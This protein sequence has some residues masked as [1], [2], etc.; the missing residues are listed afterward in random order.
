MRR[1]AITAFLLGFPLALAPCPAAMSQATSVLILGLGDETRTAAPESL[2]AASQELQRAVAL[3]APDVLPRLTPAALGVGGWGPQSLAE[4]GREQGASFVVRGGVLTVS[5][6]AAGAR[7]Y[8]TVQVYADVV[9]VSTGTVQHL[10]AAGGCA[11]D[12]ASARPAGFECALAAATVEL[13]RV[14]V[15]ALKAPADAGH[16]GPTSAGARSAVGIDVGAEP[17]EGEE[18][19]TAVAAEVASGEELVQLVSQAEQLLSGQGQASPQQIARLSAALEGLQLVLAEK[20]G[21]LQAGPGGDTAEVDEQIEASESALESVVSDAEEG[22]DDAMEGGGEG[23]EGGAVELAEEGDDAGSELET[24]EASSSGGLERASQFVELVLGTVERIQQLRSTLRGPDEGESSMAAGEEGDDIEEA[25]ADAD[26]KSGARGENDRSGNDGGDEEPGEVTGVVTEDGVPV[27]GAVVSDER[28]GVSGVTD[29]QGV[30]S[31]RGIPPDVLAKLKVR[32]GSRAVAAGGTRVVSGRAAVADFPLRR[33]SVEGRPQA[34]N[35]GARVLP[36]SVASSVSKGLSGTVRAVV[37]DPAGRPVPR[38]LVHLGGVGVGRTDSKGTCTFTRVAA[39]THELTGQGSAGSKGSQRVMVQTGRVSRVDLRLSAGRQVV[40]SAGTGLRV[41]KAGPLLRGEAARAAARRVIAGGRVSAS[42][43][44]TSS[45]TSA[46]K[47]RRAT[48]EGRSSSS[49][50]GEAKRTPGEL[51]GQV[52]DLATGRGIAGA[53]VSLGGRLR[54]TTDSRGAFTISGIKPGTH[55]LEVSREGFSSAGREVRV[56]A[57][58]S[59][60]TTVRLRSTAAAFAK[61][62]RSGR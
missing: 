5:P 18:E 7:L 44:S 10:R 31:L 27:E 62:P 56:A 14:M 11:A 61:R 22:S 24:G 35:Q 30:Y 13:A 17:E 36:S 15:P 9:A 28:S 50:S 2:R 34:R 54:A 6:S 21:V 52:T 32:I 53:R 46:S 48:E 58:S 51:R 59:G 49:R 40:P 4:L 29:R 38:A 20:A 43:A 26:G 47:N 12:G 60:T 19:E 57:G 23:E 41:S 25:D 55:R 1:P 39:G 8:T 45:R 37:V 33:T 16:I 3:A 42:S